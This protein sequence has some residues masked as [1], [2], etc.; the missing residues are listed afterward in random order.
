MADKIKWIVTALLVIGGVTGFY[1]FDQYSM[2]I[3]VPALLVVAIVCVV[4]V[5]QTVAG[6]QLV[7]FFRESQIEVRKVVWPTGKETTQTTLVV[8]GLVVVVALFLWVLDMGLLK[9]VRMLTGQ[10]S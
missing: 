4:I 1:W 6:R 7:A 3:R 10:G 2:L 5:V 8:M 9:L